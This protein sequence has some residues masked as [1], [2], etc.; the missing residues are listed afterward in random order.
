[1]NFFLNNFSVI[2]L[3]IWCLFAL[4]VIIR[5]FWPNLVR[6]ISYLWLVVI[7]FIVHLLYGSILTLLQYFVWDS[8]EFTKIFLVVPVASGVPFLELLEW[9]RPFFS[10][11]HGYFAL[12]SIQHFFM[13]T[14]VLFFIVGLFTIFFKVYKH[15]RQD[16]FIK[17]DIAVIA[18]SFLIAGYYGAIILVPIA[19][20]IAVISAILNLK[21]EYINP[22]SLPASFLIASPIGLL[23][24]IPILKYFELY[25]ILKI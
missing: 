9:A 12:Y 18:L 2:F 22:I 3:A 24:A 17:G 23:F 6:N 19:L 11:N 25:A 7:A 15:Y 14:F 10:G 1:M 21:F 4:V 5:F 20:S 8:A 16:V 13:S